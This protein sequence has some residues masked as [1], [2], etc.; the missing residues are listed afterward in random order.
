MARHEQVVVALGRVRV[1]HQTA[2]SADGAEL[3]IAAGDEFVRI[4]LV[5]GVPNEPVGAEVERRVQ[6]EAQ[7]DDA[8]VRRKVRRAV[9]HDVAQG[10]A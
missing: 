6:R 8:E 1:A 7:F 5:A 3:A 10:F 2:A 4:D 9:G